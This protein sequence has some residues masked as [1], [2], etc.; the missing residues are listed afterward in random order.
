MRLISWFLLTLIWVTVVAIVARADAPSLAVPAGCHVSAD[1]MGNVHLVLCQGD[2]ECTARV[3]DLVCGK[4][5]V[6]Q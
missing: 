4:G 6:P 2:I 3:V 5:G 1:A